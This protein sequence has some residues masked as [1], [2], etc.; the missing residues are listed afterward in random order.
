MSGDRLTR[1]VTEAL[2]PL[3]Q[4]DVAGLTDDAADRLAQ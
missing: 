3:T 4:E 1:H 2:L